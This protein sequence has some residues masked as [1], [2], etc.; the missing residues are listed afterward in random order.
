MTCFRVWNKYSCEGE[1]LAADEAHDR[2]EG[3]GPVLFGGLW[4]VAKG[5]EVE[6]EGE[7]LLWPG[8]IDEGGAQNAVKHGVG[9]AEWSGVP[10]E[11]V[12]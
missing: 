3:A 8:E 10:G 9:M 2:I 1:V 11:T 12:E 7:A 5:L 6:A 4:I